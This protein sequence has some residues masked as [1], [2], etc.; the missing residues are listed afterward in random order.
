MRKLLTIGVVLWGSVALGGCVRG[1]ALPPSAEVEYLG[2]SEAGTTHVQALSC[3]RGGLAATTQEA[4]RISFETILYRGI[5]GSE[6][7]TPLIADEA[8]ARQRFASYWQ[9]FYGGGRYRTFVTSIAQV[10]HGPGGRRGC[11]FVKL[12][13]NHVALRQ[14]L[15]QQGIIRRF[16]Y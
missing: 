14:E 13:I 6:V 3:A 8:A 4:A 7:N 10:P 5:P 1:P 12:K 15:E 16:G 2:P 9:M 11:E